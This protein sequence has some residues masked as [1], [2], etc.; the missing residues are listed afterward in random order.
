MA[1]NRIIKWQPFFENVYN[2]NIIKEFGERV[3]QRQKYFSLNVCSLYGMQTPI[4]PINKW[5]SK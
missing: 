5:L 2:I 3:G 4:H 1:Y